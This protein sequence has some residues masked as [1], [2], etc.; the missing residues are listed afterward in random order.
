MGAHH[1]P[2]HVLHQWLLAGWGMPIGELFDL[3]GVAAECER[4]GRWAFWFGSVV[5]N[6]SFL[7]FFSFWDDVFVL[8]GIDRFRVG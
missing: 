5:L 6:V 8:M 4:Q 3:E 1:D 7:F 2:A